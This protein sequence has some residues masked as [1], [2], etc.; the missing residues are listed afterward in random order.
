ML[1]R[2]AYNDVVVDHNTVSRRHTLIVETPAGFILRDLNTEDGTFVNGE[3][4]TALSHL[5]AH[6]DRIRLAS[7]EESFV[8]RLES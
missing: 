6:G 3:K 1:G 7:S 2:G 8:F 4:V 5:L